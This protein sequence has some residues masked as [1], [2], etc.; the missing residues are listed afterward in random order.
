VAHNCLCDLLTDCEDWVERSH[1]L[2]ENHRDLRAAQLTQCWLVHSRDVVASD[3]DTPLDAG[4][5]RRQQADQRAQSDTL[6]RTG[7]PEDAEHAA[8]LQIE[9]DAIDRMHGRLPGR[10]ANVQTLDGHRG[11]RSRLDAC[12]PQRRVRP[13]REDFG[14]RGLSSMRAVDA[15]V[16]WSRHIAAARLCPEPAT[17]M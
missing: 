4:A 11:L 5:P 7:L 14:Q 13:H 16:R 17:I 12:G 8:R 2:L 1:R 9:A 10:E 15:I 3:L 6:T